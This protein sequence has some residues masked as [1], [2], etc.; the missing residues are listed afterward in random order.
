MARGTLS[1]RVEQLELTVQGLE[2]LP[3]EVR[4]LGVRLGAVEGRLGGVEGRVGSLEAQ[5]SQLRDEMRSECSAV[6]KEMRDGFVAVTS[7]LGQQIVDL[8]NQSRAMFEEVLSRIALL[9]EGR[10]AATPP[11]RRKR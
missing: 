5:V 11:A 6:R 3:T 10:R 2:G 9:G 1:E 7:E 4:A 8:G